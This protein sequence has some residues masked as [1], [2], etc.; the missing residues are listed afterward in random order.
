MKVWNVA[1]RLL[2]PDWSQLLDTKKEV[3]SILDEVLSLGGAAVQFE[4]DTPLLG[5]LPD[6]DSMAVVGLINMLEERFGFVVED[7][8]ID[9]STFASVGSLVEFVDGKLA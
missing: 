1:L 6:L 5:A 8:E 9:G 3:L 2:I 4:L 7:D